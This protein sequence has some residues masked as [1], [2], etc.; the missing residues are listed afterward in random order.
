MLVC[1]VQIISR[2]DNQSKFQMVTLHGVSISLKHVENIC[3]L[4]KRADLTLGE[5]SSLLFPL[6][7]HFF[8]LSTE[9]FSIYLFIFYCVTVGNSLVTSPSPN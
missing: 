2:L 5:A 9:W 3:L 8:T 6:R 1:S 7:S 4:G